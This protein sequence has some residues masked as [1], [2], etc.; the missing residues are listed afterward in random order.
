MAPT[1]RHSKGT[2]VLIDGLEFLIS[3]NNFS[4]V[5]HFIQSLRDHAAT[6]DAVLIMPINPGAIDSKELKLLE[7]EVVEVIEEGE[8]EDEQGS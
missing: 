6:S 2:V 1:F 3:Y 7:C 4:L 5:L 8:G